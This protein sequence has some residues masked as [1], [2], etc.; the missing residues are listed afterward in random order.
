MTTLDELRE[1][2]VPIGHDSQ[3]LAALLREVRDELHELNQKQSSIFV[4]L[5]SRFYWRMT[6][7]TH[8]GY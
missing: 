5:F 8:D 7:G 2:R 1:S 6:G 4:R 3:I